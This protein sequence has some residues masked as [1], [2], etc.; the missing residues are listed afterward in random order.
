[1]KKDYVELNESI[2]FANGGTKF[3]D[4]DEGD[5]YKFRNGIQSKNWNHAI[6]NAQE[7]L[8]EHGEEIER[9]KK[10]FGFCTLQK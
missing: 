8:N 9:F 6:E 4:V 5:I 7:W 3:S 10:K 1:M 2:S